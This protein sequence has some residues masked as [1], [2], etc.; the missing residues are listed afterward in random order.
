VIN[1][2]SISSLPADIVAWLSSQEELSSIRFMTEFPPEKKAIPLKSAIV[3]VGIE[4]VSIE[5]SFSDDGN[6]VLVE[7]EYCRLAEMKIKLAIH[8]PFSEGGAKCHDVFSNVIDCLT[9]ASDLEI[10]ESGCSNI[11]ADRDT[12]A[13]VLNAWMLVSSDFCPAVSS[14]MNFQSFMNKE[15]LCGSHITDN[16]IHVTQDEKAVWNE[17]LL[18]GSYLGTGTATQ[19]ISLPFEP[20]AVI[21]F[22][23]ET[24]FVTPTYQGS[25]LYYTYAGVAGNRYGS[26]GI[27]LTSNGFKLFQGTSYQL[28]NVIPNLNRSGFHY[29]FIAFR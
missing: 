12:D 17:P 11:M 7:N 10:V 18:V 9:F 22:A 16:N 8:I 15:L 21:V 27:E 29:G 25:S 23:Q 20:K 13:L 24:A 28:D 19:S 1:L 6:G 5:D 4:E 14:S 3:A 2:S 26:L